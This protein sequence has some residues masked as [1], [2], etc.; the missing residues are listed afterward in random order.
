MSRSF[1]V[2]F[3]AGDPEQLAAFWELALD[4]V[5]QPP[6][7]GF[8]TWEAFAEQV[9]IPPEEWGTLRAL[10]DPDGIGPRLLFQR[11]PEGKVA[12]NRVHLDINAGGGH[13]VERAARMEAVEGHVA[14][15]L[16]AGATFVDRFDR[17]REY[18]VVMQDP[19]GNEFCVQ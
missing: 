10:V 9:G 2:T 14:R 12:K 8:E 6:P 5:P 3:D 18:W 13:H 4:Y 17:D 16:A 11:V 19:E 7:E 1:Q 15:L